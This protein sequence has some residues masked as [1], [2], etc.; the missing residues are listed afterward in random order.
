MLSYADMCILSIK[1][2]VDEMQCVMYEY[3]VIWSY[4]SNTQQ[5]CVTMWVEALS[6]MFCALLVGLL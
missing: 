2:C 3:L 4:S 5:S 1:S 6:S